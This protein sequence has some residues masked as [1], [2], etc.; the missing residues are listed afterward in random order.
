MSPL[1]VNPASFVGR[2]RAD[3][4]KRL[5]ERLPKLTPYTYT[6]EGSIVRGI[7][8]AVAAEIGNAYSILGYSFT[9]QLVSQATG[10]SLDAL[11]TLY[12]VTRRVVSSLT[13]QTAFY[14]YLASSDN[15][16]TGIPNMVSDTTFTIPA[17]TIIT[18]RDDVVGDT[19]RFTTSSA[20][21]FVPGDNVHYVSVVPA[22][23]ILATNMAPH[24]LRCHDY[25]GTSYTN[26]YCTNPVELN[27]DTS[28]E[29]DEDYRARMVESVRS[30]ASANKSAVRLAALSINHVRDA[31]IEDR[32]YGPASTKVVIALDYGA[33]GAELASVQTAVD[34]VRPIG[35]YVEVITA[36]TYTIDINYGILLSDTTQTAT[37]AKSVESAAKAYI[38]GLG[39]GQSLRKSQLLAKMFTAAPIALDVYI[40]NIKVN[41]INFIGDSY[42][43]P[44]DGA[45]TL[46]SITKQ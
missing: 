29:S 19:F 40:T 2:T 33:S 23:S 26:V 6:G 20:V 45:F 5:L 39:I 36:K 41:G 4:T 28:L 16:Q 13:Q 43:L 15:H 7:L 42:P 3:V 18:M 17:G 21:T 37:V 8:E 44:S 38:G 11:G 31:Y 27:T 10:P 32:P 46:T 9:Q 22:N 14:F 35:T 24:T 12:G 1:S 34:L 25:D 30:I